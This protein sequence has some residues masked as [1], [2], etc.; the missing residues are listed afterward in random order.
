MLVEG[1]TESEAL[2]VF[3]RRVGFD[4]V[5]EGIAIISTQGVTNLAK[6]WRLYTAYNIPTYIIFD[7]DSSEGRNQSGQKDVL[8][9]LQVPDYEHNHLL[10]SS[11]W[12]IREHFT[13]FGGNFE[14]T[15]RSYFGSEYQSK[16]TEAVELIGQ[17][18]K[19]L[20]ARY[21]AENIDSASGDGWEGFEELANAI[22]NLIT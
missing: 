1:P 9:T 5:G 17:Q 3:L 8:T 13:V 12:L 15:L 16:E 19:P 14:E 21:V 6:W 4:P 18:S 22:R 10:S 7:N 20:I 2:P 11:E